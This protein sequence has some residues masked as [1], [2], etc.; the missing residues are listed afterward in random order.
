MDRVSTLKLTPDREA[1]P[2]SSDA[3]L[4]SHSSNPE[5]LQKHFGFIHFPRKNLAKT[6][7]SEHGVEHFSS[8]LSKSITFQ[9]YRKK[10][11]IKSK[12][13]RQAFDGLEMERAIFKPE[14]SLNV[15]SQLS[16]SL[17]QVLAQH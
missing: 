4:F 12:A 3:C 7:H 6:F 11:G 2:G 8:K 13:F 16:P 10:L 5:L 14:P 17:L 9:S 15:W 1:T